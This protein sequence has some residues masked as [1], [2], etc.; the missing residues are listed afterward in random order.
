[1]QKRFYYLLVPLAAL[2]AISFILALVFIKDE[3]DKPPSLA[4]LE[5]RNI[6]TRYEASNENKQSDLTS[7][8]NSLTNLVKNFNFDLILV[9]YGKYVKIGQRL[10]L[11]NKK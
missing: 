10:Y 4:Q 7:F 6:A 9:S 5:I 3:P 1:M 2:A 8:G 11:M